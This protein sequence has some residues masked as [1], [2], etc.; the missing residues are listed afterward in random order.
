[1]FKIRGDRSKIGQ[2][3]C[4][5]ALFTTGAYGQ[6]LVGKF[7]V[8]GDSLSAGFQNF[9]LFDDT[10]AVLFG[11]EGP[12]PYTGGQ[13]SGYAAQIARKAGADSFSKSLPL[14]A[15]P[16]IPP[17]IGSGRTDIGL[18]E[19]DTQ[20][21][22]TLNLSVPGYL[23]A[24]ALGRTVDTNN[25]LP[26]N[27]NPNA[28]DL[29]AFQILAY[30]SINNFSLSST[31]GVVP[32]S[33]TK[34]LLSEAGCAVK[35][36]PDTLILWIGNNDALQ[37]LTMGIPPTN[38]LVFGTEYDLLMT[39]LKASGA[40]L[41]IANVPD[42]THLPF[43]FQ[44]SNSSYSVPNIANPPTDLTQACTR[45]GATSGHFLK[46][47]ARLVTQA[48]NAVLAYNSI[49]AAAARRF[50]A[51]LVDVYSLF[52]TIHNDNGYRVGNV[53][54]L[55]NG[56]FGGLFSWDL[57]HPTNTANAILAN[58]FI[59]AMNAAVQSQQAQIGPVCV[60]QVGAK[61]MLIPPATSAA[62]AA[63]PADACLQ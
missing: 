58:A 36:Q 19:P 63:L 55:G 18:R 46:V 59:A 52:E 53:F 40:K 49:I 2:F 22:Q 8:V 28:I 29:M 20:G 24:D 41:V 3:V 50:G 37:A 21:T 14:I 57:I 39:T 44:C 61:D 33:S 27:P 56:P 25:F 7:V 32:L 51:T 48:H 13:K 23:L 34:F 42:V 17:A 43:L 35:Q 9:S 10:G 1:M 60:N 5:L 45:D 54:P 47:S 15:W 16:G 30:P 11:P 4:I 38:S 31:C 26:T 62:F 6:S 12:F